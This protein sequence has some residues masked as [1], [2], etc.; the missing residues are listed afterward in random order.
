LALFWNIPTAALGFIKRWSKEFDD[1]F[2]TKSLII[3]LVRP[4]LEYGSPVWSPQYGIHVDRIESVQKNFLLFA[5]RRLNR[6]ANLIL[7]SYSSRLLLINGPSLANRRTMLGTVFIYNLTRGE[8]DS[9]DLVSQRNLS[10]PCGLTSNYFP[11]FVT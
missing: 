4:L 10:V 2:I 8:I 11:K 9:P 7:P 3:S 6:D 1:P 5:L